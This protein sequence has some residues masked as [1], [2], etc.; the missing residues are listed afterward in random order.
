MLVQSAQMKGERQAIQLEASNLDVRRRRH[1]VAIDQE[2]GIQALILRRGGPGQEKH[3]QERASG[4]APALRA[5]ST[6]PTSAPGLM[7]GQP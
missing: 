7:H 4:A 2:Q 1:L 6:R 3:E 5:A